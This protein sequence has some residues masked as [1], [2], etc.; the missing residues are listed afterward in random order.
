MTDPVLSKT[1]LAKAAKAEIASRVETAMSNL[2]NAVGGRDALVSALQH[3]PQTEELAFVIGIIADPR[4]DASS[5]AAICRDAGISIGKLWQFFKDADLAQA[6]VLAIRSVNRQLV[7][8]VD[9]VLKRSVEYEMVC[10]VCYGLDMGKTARGLPKPC[11][12]CG[13]KG[14]RKVEPD[15]KRQEMVLRMG[16]L[17]KDGAGVNVQ[18]NQQTNSFNAGD[19]MGKF[20]RA[21]DRMLYG[22]RERAIPATAVE[23]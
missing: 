15:L 8:V 1:A 22:E 5:L 14:F 3:A 12:N 21:S 2:E 11:P 19:A 7:A 10:D 18:V 17:L 4:N 6:Q 13:G 9:D 23:E 16:G 20:Q